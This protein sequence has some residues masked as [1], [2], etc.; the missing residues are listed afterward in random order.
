VELSV[1][2]FNERDIMKCHRHHYF[3]IGSEWSSAV[4]YTH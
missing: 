1:C 3:N 4:T 2:V